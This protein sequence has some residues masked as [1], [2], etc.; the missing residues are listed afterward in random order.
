MVK[1]YFEDLKRKR[2]DAEENNKL[3]CVLYGSNQ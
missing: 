3:V 2:A 1:D